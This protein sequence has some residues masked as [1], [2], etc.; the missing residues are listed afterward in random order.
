MKEYYK[1]YDKRY[2]IYHKQTGLA[3]MGEDASTVLNDILIKLGAN[4]RS[5]ILEIGCG[6][7]QNAL[8]LQQKGFDI[9]ATDVSSEAIN[10]CKKRAKEKKLSPEKFFVLDILNNQLS[11]KYDFILAISTLHMLVLENDRKAFFDFVFN[12]LKDKGIAIITSMGDGKQ[13]KNDSDIK[14]AF[15]LT[16]RTNNIGDFLLPNTTCRIV[17]WETLMKEVTASNLQIKEKFVSHS[18]SGFNNSM[19]VIL[20]K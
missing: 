13:I 3:W 5:K 12:H 4:Y 16:K 2:R 1:A 19:V 10:W 15:E 9:V 18:I 17:D 7:G 8:F 14:K 6:E 11:D 20:N